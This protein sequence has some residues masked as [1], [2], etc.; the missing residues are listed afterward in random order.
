[1]SMLLPTSRDDGRASALAPAAWR[2]TEIKPEAP[3]A[4][5]RVLRNGSAEVDATVADCQTMIILPA[6]KSAA[7]AVLDLSALSERVHKVVAHLH[8][9]S[10][11]LLSRLEKKYLG[12]EVYEHA[13]GSAIYVKSTTFEFLTNDLDFIDFVD[14]DLHAAE[15]LLMENAIPP[16]RQ[17]TDGSYAA[18]IPSG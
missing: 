17:S 4:I 14:M 16:F 10:A 7:G 8:I 3:D 1:M 2:L 15:Q 11:R 18:R 9:R 6:A 13:W 5:V 12:Y